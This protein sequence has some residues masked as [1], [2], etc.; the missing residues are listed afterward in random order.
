MAIRSLALPAIV[1]VAAACGG[2]RSGPSREVDVVIPTAA[3]GAKSVEAKAVPERGTPAVLPRW[4]APTHPRNAACDALEA[5]QAAEAKKDATPPLGT[6]PPSP[7]P[8]IP[9]SK[10]AW[11]FLQSVVDYSRNEL[12]VVMQPECEE[13]HSCLYDADIRLTPIRLSTTGKAIVGTPFSASH[14]GSDEWDVAGYDFDGDGADELVFAVAGKIFT[15]AN[16]N[17]VPYAPA[18]DLAFGALVDADGDGRPDLGLLEQYNGSAS[19]LAC[20]KRAGNPVLGFDVE[21]A[22]VA[23]GLAGGAFSTTDAVA[24]RVGKERCPKAPSRIAVL[25]DGSY[26]QE[27]LRENVV[28]AR[29][30]GMPARAVIEALD[31]QCTWPKGDECDALFDARDLGL[32][33]TCVGR[34]TLVA[35]ANL[36]PPLTL[37]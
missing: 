26:D 29:L 33:P 3:S 14:T 36:T 23:H 13:D 11:G 28:C 10:G 9:D 25:E 30:W 6:D 1:L 16:G 27:W 20:G 5:K 18:K 17:I 22:L 31:K 24:Q 15:I 12:N 35:W 32:T 34:D 4:T 21:T 2:A 19:L 7:P 8:C 37:K